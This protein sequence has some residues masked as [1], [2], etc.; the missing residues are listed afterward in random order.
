MIRRFG[1]LG[2]AIQR[3]YHAPQSYQSMAGWKCWD[4]AWFRIYLYEKDT[5]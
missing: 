3:R 5:L 1:R 2:F 4:A